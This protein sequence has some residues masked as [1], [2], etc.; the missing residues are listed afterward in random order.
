MNLQS[1]PYTNLDQYATF[2][3]AKFLDAGKDD[4]MNNTRRSGLGS[5]TANA[6]Q[7]DLGIDFDVDTT[8]EWDFQNWN[9][10][11]CNGRIFKTSKSGSNYTTTE[12]TGATL[13][14]GTPVTFADFGTSLYM[15]NGGRIVK[16]L[17]SAS[18]CAYIADT[19]AP[20]AVTHI[21]ASFLMLNA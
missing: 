17:A 15:A 5:D 1:K 9:V 2:G 8:Y 10:S 13:Q 6:Y 11:I 7:V 16:W 21:G 14:I 18:T 3:I 20:T 19:D 4:L 12:I